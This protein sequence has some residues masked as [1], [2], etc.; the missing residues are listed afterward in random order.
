MAALHSAR[1][2]VTVIPSLPSRFPHLRRS[3]TVAAHSLEAAIPVA[4]QMIYPPS[5][6]AH[7]TSVEATCQP[8]AERGLSN[9]HSCRSDCALE[10]RHVTAACAPSSLLLSYVQ[11]EGVYSRV[12]NRTHRTHQ[13]RPATGAPGSRY[14]LWDWQSRD[15]LNRLSARRLRW[16]RDS[17]GGSRVV[18]AGN[19]STVSDFPIPSRGC[20]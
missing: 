3:V 5:S 15:R 10:E 17:S 13:P 6:G 12:R 18:P 14:R 8:R 2:V 7:T 11:P 16:C 19:H 9:R 1:W 20:G 4:L